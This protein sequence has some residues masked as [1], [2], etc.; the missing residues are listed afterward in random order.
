VRK[1]KKIIVA[2]IGM[3]EEEGVFLP[4]EEEGG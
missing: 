4:D 3:D 1:V 2:R